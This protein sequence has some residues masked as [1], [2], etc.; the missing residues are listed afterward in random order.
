MIRVMVVA[1]WTAGAAG[2][3][4]AQPASAPA[5]AP[6]PGRVARLNEGFL[7]FVAALGPEHAL[8]R[9]AILEAWKTRYRDERPEDFV[10][11]AVAVL[12]PAAARALAL[13][14]AGD[15]EGA[16]RNF[17]V[18]GGDPDPFL[19]AH[20]SYYRVRILTALG[21]YET[22]A[23]E[24]RRLIARADWLAAHTPFAPRVWLIRAAG[25][26]R[27]LR[28]ADALATL[29]A[30]EARFA[31]LPEPVRVGA[32]QLRLEIE[33]REQ[34][35]LGEVAQVMD[36]VADRL[37][38][39]DEGARLRHEQE[40]IVAL[41]DKLI[42]EHEQREAKGGGK[43]KQGG[44]RA[45]GDPARAGDRPRE[46]SVAPGGAGRVGD[47][48][49]APEARP[50]EAWGRLPPAERQRILQSIRERFP[51]RYRELVEQYYRS[52]AEEK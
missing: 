5:G 51:S 9:S 48:H 2:A 11:E 1:V 15:L 49:G 41:L 16:L 43:C 8:A 22:A 31:E 45:Q 20:A 32:A 38:V 19:A 28:F 26:F 25:A 36:F 21:R 12:H 3:L 27:S 44:R 10:P 42:Q 18:L 52:L 35:T 40:R 23:T 6:A 46:N 4:H 29:D 39:A 50:G 14:D 47:L 30:L 33:R 24:A 34:G 7:R 37:R 13:F 17:T